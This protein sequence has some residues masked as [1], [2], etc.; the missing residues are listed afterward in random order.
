MVLTDRLDEGIPVSTKGLSVVPRSQR[1]PYADLRR[2]LIDLRSVHV[3]DDPVLVPAAAVR[4]P[5]ELG[6]HAAAT[7]SKVL[8]EA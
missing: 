6:R 3:P 7:S 4:A 5:S 2:E 8:Q 1:Y